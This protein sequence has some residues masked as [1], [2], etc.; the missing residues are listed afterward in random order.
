MIRQRQLD[1]LMVIFERLTSTSSIQRIS[2]DTYQRLM[3]AIK[4]DM[5]ENLIEA[6]WK[7]L[8]A[9]NKEDGLNIKQFNELLFNLNFDLRQQNADQTM[10]QKTCPSIYN[11]KPSRIIIDFMST[12]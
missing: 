6:Y 4:T 2:Y 7:T 12:G 1:A 5:T 10:I 9:S 11:S 3:R 8:D